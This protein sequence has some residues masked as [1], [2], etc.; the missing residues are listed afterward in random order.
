MGYQNSS[1][2]DWNNS[3]HPDDLHGVRTRTQLKE[4]SVPSFNAERTFDSSLLEIIFQKVKFLLLLEK[5]KSMSNEFIVNDRSRTNE[6]S[7][8]P[9]GSVVTVVHKDGRRLVYDKIK[10]PQ[11]Y[12]NRACG[13]ES[14][15]EILLD[16]KKVYP[17][18]PNLYPN[19]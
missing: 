12:I 17:N 5:R 4:R 18:I 1:F 7:L 6:L 9:G 13:D 8:S 11:A 15:V 16:G 2:D 3:L 10:K 19:L 14:V